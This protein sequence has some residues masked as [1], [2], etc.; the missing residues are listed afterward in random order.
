M[1][2]SIV[3]FL[4]IHINQLKVKEREH[5]LRA[6]LQPLAEITD[7]LVGLFTFGL[8]HPSF[9]MRVV[10]MISKKELKT[11]MK[12]QDNDSL[13]CHNTQKNC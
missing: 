12:G 3:N 4:R 13:S 2:T 1:I 8:V 6:T 5:F 7:G 10:L 11:V 9:T